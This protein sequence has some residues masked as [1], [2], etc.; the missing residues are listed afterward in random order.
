VNAVLGLFGSLAWLFLLLGLAIAVIAW[1]VRAHG[2]FVVLGL[3]IVA[4]ICF[5]WAWSAY[6]FLDAVRSTTAGQ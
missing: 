3:G 2:P 1:L 6:Q 4:G 5:G